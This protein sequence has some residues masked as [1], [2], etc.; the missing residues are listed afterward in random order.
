MFLTLE[1]KT[2]FVGRVCPAMIFKRTVL[3]PMTIN[4]AKLNLLKI[5][6]TLISLKG[7]R[8]KCVMCAI[9]FFGKNYDNA[10]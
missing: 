5:F 8:K 4:I 6:R 10:Q 1:A 2:Y 9:N 3:R 7:F